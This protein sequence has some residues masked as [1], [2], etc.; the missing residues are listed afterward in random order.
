MSVN[1]F[2]IYEEHVLCHKK[3]YDRTKNVSKRFNNKFKNVIR[4]R[5]PNIFIFIESLQMCNG[6]AVTALKKKNL[7]LNLL[8][9]NHYEDKIKQ[10]FNEFKCNNDN[11]ILY[12]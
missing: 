10:H 3:S 7:I 4:I 6:S 2:T 11:E 12:F 9:T 8:V 1:I 5:H